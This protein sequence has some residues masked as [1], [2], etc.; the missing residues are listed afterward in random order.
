[1]NRAPAAR[2]F[3]LTRLG[4]LLG[5]LGVL[6]GGC[7]SL[8]GGVDREVALGLRAHG[9]DPAAIVVPWQL[10]PEMRAWVHQHVPDNLAAEDRLTHLLSALLASDG[11]ALS[12]E[13]GVTTTA[14]EVFASH[15]ANCLAFTSLFVGLAREIGVPVF[16]LE[17]GDVERF[18]REGNLVIES[19]HVTAGYGS[20]TL[21]RILDFTPAAKTNYR[22]YRRLS[23]LTA[24]ALFYSNRGAELLKE[25][26]APE[27]VGWLRTATRV[28]PDLARGWV[29][30]GVALRRTGDRQAAEAAYRRALEADP[31]AVAAYQNLAALLFAS[32]RSAE[33]DELMA[34][35]GRLDIHNPFNF[36]A[37]GDVAVAHGRIDEAKRFYHRA[38]RLEGAGAEA[39]AALGEVALAG[40]DRREA[41]RWLRKAGSS[42]DPRVQRLAARLA[43]EPGAGRG[44][45]PGTVPAPAV[46]AAGSGRGPDPPPAMALMAAGAGRAAAL[47]PGPPPG[48]PEGRR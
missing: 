24:I 7:S 46:P 11:L 6:S 31:T 45:P 41:K 8:G 40:G 27:A 17:I 44:G 35:S 14:R 2:P 5:L 43:G 10:D 4:S 13:A 33:G 23:D 29:N 21:L 15:H 37:L 16:Y 1:M 26:R 36:L 47:P 32:G 39:A 42:T 12:Y 48:R 20:G 18:E 19:G 30:Y 34:L 9:L 25:G 22:Q 3:R 38:L 28:D